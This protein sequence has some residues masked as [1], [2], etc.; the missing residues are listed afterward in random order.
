M[1]QKYAQKASDLALAESRLEAAT[2]LS[3]E[4][5][6]QKKTH[7]VELNQARGK[8]SEELDAIEAL[9][10]WANAVKDLTN[11]EDAARTALEL[12]S[13][14]R[15]NLQ[16]EK[17]RLERAQRATA[18]E[19]VFAVFD[20]SR[21]DLALVAEEQKQHGLRAQE[22]AGAI[23]QAQSLSAEANQ[24]V[25][26]ETA[27]LEKLRLT[28]RDV[29]ALDAA[30]AQAAKE[31]QALQKRLTFLETV[32]AALGIEA[33]LVHA[34]AEDG[35][36]DPALRERFDCATARAVAGMNVLSEYCLPFV[37]TGGVFAALKGPQME[38]ELPLARKAISVLG[39][40]VERVETYALP[41]GDRRALALVRKS[42]PTPKAYPR[43]GGKIKKSPL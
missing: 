29:R 2:S 35:G 20:Q 11:E 25:Q 26:T 27:V 16:S 21:K 41:G 10:K 34:R 3:Q 6:D 9:L 40:K 22:V 36:R 14:A 32:C 18:L 42:R 43:Q 23:A 30:L 39:G 5:I 24:R 28:L 31:H 7:R 15:A 37:K 8:T 12:N 13:K 17:P 33:A 19:G 1:Q 38:E 4:E